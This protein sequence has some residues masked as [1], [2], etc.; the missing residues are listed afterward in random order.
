MRVTASD[1]AEFTPLALAMR[2]LLEP[3]LKPAGAE[4]GP[5]K[6]RR[7]GRRV[8][9]SRAPT[10]M[11]ELAAF[12]AGRR[13][14]PV[15][16]ENGAWSDRARSAITRLERAGEDALTLGLAVPGLPAAA[17]GAEKTIANAEV[18][19]S[20]AVVRYAQNARGKRVDPRRISALIDVRLAIPAAAE[21][22]TKVG[23]AEFAGDALQAFNPQHPGYK[24][25]RAKLAEIR[26]P[27]DEKILPPIALGRTLRVG[28]RDP[29]VPTLR[30]RFGLT[31]AAD[32]SQANLYD[33]QVAGA[34]AAF[35]RSRGLAANG[36]LT[37]ATIRALSGSNRDRLTSEVIANMERWRWLPQDIGR[38]HF[39]ANIPEYLV[40]MFRDGREIHSTRV[41][42][43][44]TDN[45]TPV[46]SE[47]MATIVVNPYWNVPQSIIKKEMLPAYQRNGDY[48]SRRGY[49]VRMRGN[50]ITVRQPPGPR[51]ALG[52]VKLLFPNRHAVYM[53]DTPSRGLFGASRRAF[54]HGCVRVQ[55]PF[56]VAALALNGQ[57]GLTESRLKSMIGR[58]ERWINLKEKIPV[59][60]VYF[61]AT[62]D[63]NGELRLFNDVYGHSARLRRAMGLNG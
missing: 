40:R 23:A 9:R 28:M 50:T 3:E 60:I 42:V 18:Q 29:R 49:E 31:A 58:G 20:R 7:G 53:H 14:V 56:K 52:Y 48:F 15:W 38:T 39:M 44:K 61:T 33:T 26:G 30:L 25:L 35:Q 1:V 32:E 24:A 6:S 16:F 43:G 51:N 45:Q 19:L 13:F 21:I 17:K 55:N 36:R 5:S 4:A 8:V 11:Q 54:S 22:L 57:N 37:N 12:Y 46:F 62:I 63:E 2:A 10:E 27:A 47:N 59:H 41:I 34:V